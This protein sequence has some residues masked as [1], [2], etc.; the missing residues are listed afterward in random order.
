[1]AIV[2]WYTQ[3]VSPRIRRTKGTVLLCCIWTSNRPKAG[4]YERGAT[5][6]RCVRPYRPCRLTYDS[7]DRNTTITEATK[8][9]TYTRDA[10]G[11]LLTRTNT[12]GTT[13]TNKYIYTSS[14]DTPDLLLDSTNAIVERYLQLPGGVTKTY[15]GSTTRVFSIPN[16]HGDVFATTDEN[17]VQ[18]GTF[19]YDPFGNKTSTT[20]PNNTA[21]NSTFGWVG[22]H[23]KDAETSFT[24]APTQM[25]ARVYLA[26]IGRFLQVDPVEGGTPSNYTYPADPVNEGDLDGNTTQYIASP[27]IAFHM[28]CTLH[29]FGACLS[30]A[31]TVLSFT[32]VGAA[33][34]GTTRLAALA[35]TEGRAGSRLGNLMYHFGKHGAEMGYNNPVSYTIGAVTNAVKSKAGALLESGSR[36]FVNTVN[37][38]ITLT[39][40]GR[41]SNFMRA[42]SINRWLR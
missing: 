27:I 34:A 23:E 6:L 7:S 36:S 25:G 11:R 2:A 10:Q 8:V 42:N 39:Y 31:A 26:T 12:N 17:G 33:R 28:D 20:Y 37:K 18:T 40:K 35:W 13:I 21:N 19:S 29:G 41:I 30:H 4:R 5:F 38:R 14:S 1:V 22:Q 15:R 16:L 3:L 32:P 24:L 9:T